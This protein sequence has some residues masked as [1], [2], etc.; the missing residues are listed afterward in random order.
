MINNHLELPPTEVMLYNPMI[1]FICAAPAKM[2]TD[3]LENK[4]T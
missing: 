2:K 4:T 1:I 3:V